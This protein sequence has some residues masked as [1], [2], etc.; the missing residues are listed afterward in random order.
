MQIHAGDLRRKIDY[1]YHRVL[2]WLLYWLSLNQDL[3]RK[4]NFKINFLPPIFCTRKGKKV[5]VCTHSC[6]EKSLNFSSGGSYINVFVSQKKQVDKTSIPQNIWSYNELYF[7]YVHASWCSTK[8]SLINSASTSIITQI[9]C[10]PSSLDTGG[11]AE[12]SRGGDP[13]IQRRPWPEYSL[14]DLVE[15]SGVW[16][17]LSLS[18]W[19]NQDRR[20]LPETATRGGWLRERGVQWHQTIVSHSLL[21]LFVLHIFTLFRK[22][23]LWYEYRV[24]LSFTVDCGYPTLLTPRKIWHNTLTRNSNL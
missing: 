15:S 5:L 17:G 11:A 14:H 6:N 12:C 24:L 22:S 20:L 13:S 10:F 19:R 1:K 23:E 2:N 9:N 7:S 18:E 3:Y 16:G 8:L 21:T 4:S